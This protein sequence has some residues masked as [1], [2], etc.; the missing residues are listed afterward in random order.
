[1]SFASFRTVG[2]STMISRYFYSTVFLAHV[3]FA[4]NST[5]CCGVDVDQID[6][7]TKEEWCGNATSTCGQLAQNIYQLTPTQAKCNEVSMHLSRYPLYYYLILHST[8]L[9]LAW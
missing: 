5:A 3:A 1:M 8:F 6:L 2:S 4:F 7:T 9:M